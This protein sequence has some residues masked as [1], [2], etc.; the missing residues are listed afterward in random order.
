MT[1]KLGTRCTLTPMT[2]AEIKSIL[3]NQY[4]FPNRRPVLD[5]KKSKQAE[6]CETEEDVVKYVLQVV[7]DYLWLV[8]EVFPASKYP[9]RPQFS[10]GARSRVSK[11]LKVDPEKDLLGVKTTSEDREKAQDL[12]KKGE[13]SEAKEEL[14][15][16]AK[17]ILEREYKIHRGRPPNFSPPVKATVLAQSRPF[18]EWPL[19]QAQEAIQTRVFGWPKDT[20]DQWVAHKKSLKGEEF[21]EKFSKTTGIPLP[22]GQVSALNAIFKNAFAIYS[23]V[24]TKVQN[25]NAKKLEKLKKK[26]KE[27]TFEEETA[28]TEEGYLV[29]PPG[30]NTILQCVQP[31]KALTPL[32]TELRKKRTRKS[33]K[34]VEKLSAISD[35]Y[36]Q[37][38]SDEPLPVYGHDHRLSIPEGSP[39]YIPDHAREELNPKRRIRLRQGKNTNRKPGHPKYKAPEDRIGSYN[40]LRKN[41]PKD[42]YALPIVITVGDDWVVVDARALLR[43]ARWRGLFPPQGSLDQLLD[44]FSGDPRLDTGR[45]WVLQDDKTRVLDVREPSITYC[46]AE[47]AVPVRSRKVVEGEKKF[48]EAISNEVSIRGS[49]GLLSVDLGVI[50]PVAAKIYTVAEKDGVLV[51]QQKGLPVGLPEA[52]LSKIERYKADYTAYQRKFEVAALG[53]LDAKHRGEFD[54][55]ESRAS[56]EKQ[57]IVKDRLCAALG[58]QESPAIPWDKMTSH[59]TFIS[60]YLLKNK[61]ATEDVLP[62]NFFISDDGREGLGVHSLGVFRQGIPK[63]GKTGPGKVASDW[64]WFKEAKPHVSEE[65]REAWR[66]ALETR[67]RG[68]EGYQRFT[69]RA[70]ELQRQAVNILVRQTRKRTGVSRVVVALEDLGEL[71]NRMWSGSGKRDPGWGNFVSPKS[72]SRWFVQGFHRTFCELVD[73][74]HLVGKEPAPSPSVD[75]QSPEV[76]ARSTE[77]STSV[78]TVGTKDMQTSMWRLIISPRWPSQGPVC[79]KARA[80]IVRKPKG[81]LESQESP[82]FQLTL[83]PFRTKRR[84]KKNKVPTP[85][86]TWCI[87]HHDR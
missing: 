34:T 48:Q 17:E 67:K 13:Y 79:E 55:Y 41:D 6:E 11:L 72:E 8:D 83:P 16:Q 25:R 47:G 2:P 1:Q 26:G 44:L 46:Y 53:D 38:C 3:G 77:K 58:I 82:R 14:R 23:G 66:E 21:S 81:S 70:K 9:T 64:K 51:K 22:D 78:N 5:A 18:G 24:E 84:T 80:L 61:M 75:A 37:G 56:S 63:K 87:S 74:G 85:L 50:N 60:D 33:P 57:R 69:K 35:C 49:V 27:S 71:D 36:S 86:A 15:K 42:S 30:V 62:A 76:A 68:H 40:V 4:H 73:K 20:Y 10:D 28:Y 12:A 32:S 19:V 7:S 29:N 31:H 54:A 65:A 39:G 43:N 59:T 52:T 45:R